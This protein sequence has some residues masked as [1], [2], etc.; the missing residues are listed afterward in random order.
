MLLMNILSPGSLLEQFLQTLRATE[1]GM[2]K[3]T[4]G[5]WHGLRFRYLCKS[6]GL[7]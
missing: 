1:Y 2:L 5:G 4:C 7:E 3:V 6:V